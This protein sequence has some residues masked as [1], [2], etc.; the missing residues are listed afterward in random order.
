MTSFPLFLFPLREELVRISVMTQLMYT[1]FPFFYQNGLEWGQNRKR[2]TLCGTK[3]KNTLHTAP[4]P[5]LTVCAPAPAE[6]HSRHNPH[7]HTDEDAQPL[8]VMKS[9]Q[10]SSCRRSDLIPN[11]EWIKSALRFSVIMCSCPDTSFT[12]STKGKQTVLWA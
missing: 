4:W 3:S 8:W 7:P 9:F 5:L 11:L 1:Y 6:S 2:K 12:S 10:F